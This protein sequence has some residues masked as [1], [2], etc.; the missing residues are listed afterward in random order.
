MSSTIDIV[1]PALAGFAGTVLGALITWAAAAG[2]RRSERS[3]EL[4]SESMNYFAALEDLREEVRARTAK[5]EEFVGQDLAGYNGARQALQRVGVAAIAAGIDSGYVWDVIGSSMREIRGLSQADQ[6]RRVSAFEE[7]NEH[8]SSL[9]AAV[10]ALPFWRRKG[11]LMHPDLKNRREN[12]E[13][14]SDFW[15][16]FK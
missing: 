15:R 14:L 10:T 11:R 12:L 7:L 3:R 6:L 13:I 1:I 2:Q 16:S 9:V 4:L 8:A 5:K